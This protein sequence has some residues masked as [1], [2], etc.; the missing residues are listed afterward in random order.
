MLKKILATAILTILLFHSMGAVTISVAIAA[1]EAVQTNE[2]AEYE[3]TEELEQPDENR[4]GED[5]PVRPNIEIE[6]DNTP[7]DNDETD[8]VGVDDLGDPSG[9][10]EQA[11]TPE[12]ILLREPML[13]RRETS[14]G[15]VVEVSRYH[16]TYR[17]GPNQYKQIYTMIPQTFIARNGRE[18]EIDNTL[19]T[20]PMARGMG[21]PMYTNM[22]S[23][24]NVIL[25]SEITQSQG[26]ITEHEGNTVVLRPIGGD[27]TNSVVAENAIRYN[28]VFDNIDFQYT[29]GNISLHESII[30]NVQPDI[31]EFQYELILGDN[32]TAVLI[33]NAIFIFEDYEEGEENIPVYTIQAPYM[34]DANFETNKNVVLELVGAHDCAQTYIVTLILDEEWLESFEIAFPVIMSSTVTRIFRRGQGN[35]TNVRQRFPDL[36]YGNIH[37]IYTGFENGSVT[38]Q[39]PGA[40]MGGHLMTRAYFSVPLGD[41][42]QEARIDSATLTLTQ[43]SVYWTWPGSSSRGI[44][45]IYRVNESWNSSITWANQPIAGQTFISS[46]Q[47]AA[48][49]N[50]RLHFDMRDQVNDWVQELYPNYGIAIRMID[51]QNHQA[52]WLGTPVSQETAPFLDVAPRLTIEFT[53]PDPVDVNMPLN[54]LSVNLRA[55][56]ETNMGGLLRFNGA[57]LDGVSRPETAVSYW[58]EPGSFFGATLAGFSYRFPN[59]ENFE[60]N[61]P[62]SNRFRDRLANWQSNTVFTNPQF[63]RRHRTF[64]RAAMVNDEGEIVLSNIRE[65]DSFVIYRVRQKDTIPHIAA[66]YGVP[67]NTIMRDNR[68]QD[69]L[70][71]ENNTLFIRNPNHNAERPFNPPPLTDQRRR[72]I[73]GA[74]RGRNMK[75]EYGFDPVNLNTGNFYMKSIDATIPDLGG[76]FQIRRTYNSKGDIHNSL[77]GRGWNFEFSESLSRL[78]DGTIAYF[79]GDGK[80][81]YFAPKDG[82]GFYSP[83]DTHYEIIAIP[84]DSVWINNDGEEENITLYRYDIRNTQTREVRSFNRFGLLTNIIDYKGNDTRIEYDENYIINRLISPTGRAYEI[85]ITDGRITAITLPNGG[86]LNYEYDENNNLVKFIDA[87]GKV[88]TYTYNEEGLMRS[89][90]QGAG[91]RVIYNIYDEYGRVIKQYDGAGNAGHLKFGDGVTITIDENGDITTIHYNE[92][93]WTTKIV[94]PDGSI[95]TKEYDEVG[96]LIKHTNEAGITTKFEHDSNRN[97]IKEIRH[98]GAV[99]LA[100]FNSM[101]LPISITDFDGSI[102]TFTYDVRGNMLTQTNSLGGVRSFTYDNQNRV[103]SITDEAGNTTI[104]TYTG[105]N[106][107]SITNA[108]NQ[109]TR[110]YYNTMNQIITVVNPAGDIIRYTYNLNGDLITVT[111]ENGAVTTNIYD[112][113]RRKIAQVDPLGNRTSF[114]HNARGLVSAGIDA[115]GQILRVEYDKT[116]YKVREIDSEGNITKWVR[117]SR[118]NVVQITDPDGNTIHFE[119]DVVGNITKITDANGNSTAFTHDLVLNRLT[120]M[121]SPLGGI[122]KYEYDTVGNLLTITNPEGEITR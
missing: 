114:A 38:E 78:E 36:P 74:L 107:T 121:T 18:I 63:D 41:I 79:Q 21:Q 91:N 56:T 75:C 81:R 28:N 82:G 119:Y 65:G 106:V 33:A 89:F 42:P 25:P 47:V 31:T 10:D 52:E 40:V 11:E 30:L 17:T 85:E 90:Y 100:T 83:F 111:D 97:V 70:L 76:D 120:S 103:T 51:E 96:N 58:I 122:T 69:T 29:V 49:P 116:G 8:G 14:P 68:M 112:N 50:S 108:L 93:F 88:I 84:F 60:A 92:Y 61:F 54:N 109:T 26:I 27:F 87:E 66:Y 80:V 115:S 72:E 71:V 15:K 62:N 7:I 34:I 59:T 44:M 13:P 32:L 43:R 20:S 3:E 95:E 4:V 1:I 117:D 110:F 77:F 104:Y 24:F 118:N 16:T 5:D 2:T 37:S 99:K 67:L 113:S 39:V 9:E 55:L 101:N 53:I 48:T 46:T 94:H 73:D 22:A 19:I 86:V 57:F 35:F 98:D 12:E 23:D 64:A 6:P 102:T 105:A 45:A